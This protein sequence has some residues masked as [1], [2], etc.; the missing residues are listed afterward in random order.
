MK[1]PKVLRVR[2][3]Y[4]IGPKVDVRSTL[5]EE[6]QR[7]A[8]RIRNG[9]RIAVGV[10]S[11]GISNLPL[12]VETVLEELQGYGAKPFLIPAMG[13]HG[14]ATAEGQ[15]EV[16][17]TYGITE[18]SMR[19]PILDSMEVAQVGISSDGI[20]AYCSTE[21]RA[22]DGILLINRIKPHTDF[23]GTLGSGLTK[24]CVIGLGKRTGA[25]A[26]HLAAMQFGHER[27]IRNLAKVIIQNSPVLGGIAIVENQV[28]DTAKIVAVPVEEL[29]E[30][31]NELLVE[32]KSMM[33]QLPFDELDLLIVD[34]IGKNISGAGMDPNVINRSVHGYDSQPARG[35]RSTPFVRRI[36]VR[37][38]SPETHG[39][40]IGIGMADA[41]TTRLIASTDMRVTNI[42][43]LTALTPQSAKIPIAFETDREAIEQMLASLPISNLFDAKVVRVLDTLS[44]A[45]MEISESLWNE[46]SL[47]GHLI[48]LSELMEFGFDNEGNLTNP[49]NN[50]TL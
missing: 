18:D 9:D 41:V 35:E 7:F 27:V 14:G 25:N 10:G 26:M 40:A 47:N 24:M 29:E 1:L 42:N 34:Q 17:A 2:Q 38:L 32:A 22:A 5:K 44:V 50:P 48:A 45:E 36:Y 12:I 23:F 28:H 20:P 46:H 3:N 49:S 16:L 43:A 6:M 4:A 31:E 8:G 30:M 39:N 11:R 13:S 21:A 15:R 33:P 19:V 37:N